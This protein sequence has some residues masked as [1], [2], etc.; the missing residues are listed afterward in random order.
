MRELMASLE[1]YD[2]TLIPEATVQ[3]RYEQSLDSG[4]MHLAASSDSLRGEWQDLEG[5]LR[6]IR[7]RTLFA[8]GMHDAFLTPDYPL[9]LARMV[10]HGQL[11]V[12][13]ARRTTSRRSGRGTTWRWSRGFLDQ[14]EPPNASERERASAVTLAVTAVRPCVGRASARR[15]A[16]RLSRRAAGLVALLTARPARG[17]VRRPASG[18]IVGTVRRDRP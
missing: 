1:W 9:M 10:P 15:C 13:D 12:M 4:E 17:S 11:F 2:A 14:S 18:P 3:R 5:H 16:V 6:A 8:W 7:C